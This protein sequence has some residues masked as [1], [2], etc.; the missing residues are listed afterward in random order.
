MW[1]GGSVARKGT[2]DEEG[3]WKGYLESNLEVVWL[4]EDFRGV[5]DDG[6]EGRLVAAGLAMML[7]MRMRGGEI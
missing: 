6:L 3:G 4:G 2:R 1:V 7:R 5:L